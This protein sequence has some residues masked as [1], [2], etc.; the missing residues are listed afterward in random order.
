[1]NVVMLYEK[2]EL[3]M[4]CMQELVEIGAP[5]KSKLAA[6]PANPQNC[7]CLVTGLH[8]AVPAYIPGGRGT[9]CCS[10]VLSAFLFSS[11]PSATSLL[12]LP[13]LLPIPARS[14]RLS[15][16]VPG[17]RCPLLLVGLGEDLALQI[18]ALIWC[19]RF[20]SLIYHYLLLKVF[21]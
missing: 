12:L 14:V 17:W 8:G 16:H 21:I 6:G 10:L 5:G 9:G 2:T 15:L 13:F 3:L 7:W 18:R 1:M 11:G 20:I 4:W 19:S